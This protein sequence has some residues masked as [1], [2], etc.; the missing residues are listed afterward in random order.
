[1]TTTAVEVERKYDVDASTVLPDLTD[2]PG[3][4]RV[5][6]PQ[7]HELVAHYFDTADLSL[8]YAGVTLRHRAGGVDSGWHLKVP[9]GGDR[10]ELAVAGDDPT[11]DVPEELHALVRALVRGQPLVPVARLT[12]R[13]TAHRLLDGAGEVLAEVVDDEVQGELVGGPD[14][15]PLRW[16]EWEVELGSGERAV[17]DEVERALLGAGAT[18]SSSSSK[19][20]RVLAGRAIEPG[21]PAWWSGTLSRPASAGQVVQA[22]LRAQVDELIARDP[23]VRRDLPDAVHR[24]RVATRRLR[25]A[26]H[27]FR[28]LLDR[29]ATDPLRDELRRLAGI[30]GEARDVEVLHVRLAELV[31]AQPP[32]LVLGPVLSKVT[33]V[34]GDRY[35]EAHA[36]VVA[37]LDSPRY[38]HLLDDLDALATAPPFQDRARGSDREVLAPL[39]ERAWTRLDRMMNAAEKAAGDGAVGTELDD[40][41]HEARKLAKASRYAAESVE[42]SFGL[43]ATRFARAMEQLQ[44]VLGEH[45]D[46]VLT[47]EVLLELGAGSTLPGDNGFTFGRL[48]GLEQARA[49]STVARWPEVRHQVSRRKLRRWMEQPGD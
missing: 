32:E 26:L 40:L 27:T 17:L 21:K 39:V 20:G 24:M 3:V 38:L 18:R 23:Q 33:T 45:Q 29:E 13:R 44:E 12:T 6:E 5:A 36:R 22:H 7:V 31:R 25:A 14:E 42:P 30:L 16:R 43:K 47:R 41:L 34:M 2:V 48:H 49:E 19:V 9:I 4:T 37:E 10:E 28:P 8:R 35:R 1:M 15:E 11:A 46:G